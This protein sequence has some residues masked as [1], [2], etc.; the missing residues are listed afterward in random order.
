MIQ[1]T[2]RGTHTRQKDYTM[3][4]LHT[5]A[6]EFMEPIFHW[7]AHKQRRGSIWI[8]VQFLPSSVQTL[9]LLW[10]ISPHTTCRSLWLFWLSL[11]P[12]K[13]KQTDKSKINQRI[14]KG[15][16]APLLIWRREAFGVKSFCMERS[17]TAL[18]QALLPYHDY[19]GACMCKCDLP[20]CP[21]LSGWPPLCGGAP[22]P[23]FWHCR[24]PWTSAEPERWSGCSERPPGWTPPPLLSSNTQM[25]CIVTQLTTGW[26]ISVSV[27]HCSANY[28]AASRIVWSLHNATL[29]LESPLFV[30]TKQTQCQVKTE[31][32]YY[33]D[34][35]QLQF[36]CV[37]YSRHS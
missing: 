33:S 25:F 12:V 29:V 27:T 8:P 28:G 22:A 7:G 20:P 4:V 15:K 14:S 24:S 16:R 10:R 3:K 37:Q 5:T 31:V 32:H 36:L 11:Q 18:H 9:T 26:I 30:M 13:Y 17:V 23:R 21:H 1:G 34:K 19:V 35:T 6:T 2:K